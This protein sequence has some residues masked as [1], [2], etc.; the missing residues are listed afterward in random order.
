MG[1][2]IHLSCKGGFKRALWPVLDS[3]FILILVSVFTWIFAPSMLKC[4]GISMILGCLLSMFS[5]LV[6]LRLFV[7]NYLRINSTKAKKLGLYRDKN[8]KEVKDEEV[9]IIK[10]EVITETL[11]GGSHE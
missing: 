4:F 9:Q 11:E 5:S 6:L 1:K 7:K 3:H 8:I 2:K 10:E